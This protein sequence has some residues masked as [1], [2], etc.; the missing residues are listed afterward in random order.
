M[1]K[2]IDISTKDRAQRSGGTSGNAIYEMVRRALSRR[3]IKGSVAVDLGC[4]RGGLAEV[5]APFFTRYIGADAVR[6]DTFPASA[7]FAEIDLNRAPF[8][9]DAKKADA[10][11]A[12]E[13]IEHLENPRALLR[14]MIRIA[15]PGG[16]IIV[17]TPNQL[18][19]LS[20]FTLVIKRRFSAFQ[21]VHYPA[22]IT[23]LLEIDLLRIAKE[24]GLTDVA[25]EF[26][27]EGRI[28]LTPWHYPAFISCAFP[29]A[30]SDNI[31]L[32]GRAP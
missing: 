14:E 4:G 21:D 22:H 26:S 9:I 28:V 1:S 6:Y 29:R 7:E 30:C 10:V 13:T 19:F 16:W 32:I 23:A 18:S 2:E 25:T 12:I 20:L 11:F 17:T 8:G 15:K 31:L 5:I 24:V 3:G 27:R